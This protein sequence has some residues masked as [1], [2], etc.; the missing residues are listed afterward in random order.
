VPYRSPHRA[1]LQ[2]GP[3]AGIALERVVEALAQ[4]IEETWPTMGANRNTTTVRIGQ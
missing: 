3:L 2:A 1:I 4:L